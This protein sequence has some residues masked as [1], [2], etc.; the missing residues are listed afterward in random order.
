MAPGRRIEEELDALRASY[1]LCSISTD[2]IKHLA[3]TVLEHT[4]L[5]NFC[6]IPLLSLRQNS[7]GELDLQ[8]KGIGTVGAC[9]EQPPASAQRSSH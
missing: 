8:G 7:V 9:A 3:K 5:I 6:E 2:G 1:Q 4:V